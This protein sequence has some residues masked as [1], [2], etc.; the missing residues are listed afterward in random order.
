MTTAAPKDSARP[1]RPA[2]PP[3]HKQ[4][5]KILTGLVLALFVSSLSATVVATALPTIVGQLGGQDKLAW[6][7]SATLLTTTASTPLWGKMSDLYGR[8][9]LFM[10]SI[11]VF[12]VASAL[13]GLSQN[14]EQLIAAR[15]LQGVGAGGLQALTQA[16][17]ADIVSPRERGRYSGYLGSSFGM[18]T[19]AGPLIG[20]FLVD[21]GNSGWRWCFYVGIPI[22]VIALVVVQRTLHLPKSRR[23][24][25]VDYWGAATL[26]GSVTALLLLLSLGGKEFDWMSGVTAV[27][28]CVAALLLAC[29]VLVERRVPEPILPPRLF[30]QRTFVL[31]GIAGFFVGIAMFGALSYLPLYLQIVKGESATVSGLLTVPLI[32]G[33]LTASIG[34]GQLITRLGRWKVF[35]FVGLLLVACGLY[36]LSRLHVRTP[37]A[38]T[39]CYM[40][41]LGLGI[42]MTMQV[43]VLAVQ[44]TVTRQDIG[45]ATS[46]S[47]FFRSMGGAVGVAVFG[48]ILNNRLTDLLPRLLAQRHVQ[49]PQGGSGGLSALLGSPQELKKFPAPL[50]D[51]IREGFTESL[52]VVFLV[53]VPLAILG[54][55]AVTLVREVPLRTHVHR[56]PEPELVG[57]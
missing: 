35:P 5:V 39:G 4:I 33:L 57:D 49:V 25:K 48:A 40:V 1:A 10:L 26:T 7:I 37:L 3:D 12:V 13:A 51:V 11:V 54:W 46:A 17:M 47:S 9:P 43:L 28:A 53:G 19:V 31:T 56:E 36:L 41:V 23:E 42:G 24:V 6:V 52:H 21:S 29:A 8:K 14:I 32:V 34:S 15:A 45:V 50:L 22:A 44:N 16:I 20:G 2:A 38:V 30:R 55:I 27:L 18:A